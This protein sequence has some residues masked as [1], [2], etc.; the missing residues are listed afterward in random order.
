MRIVLWNT[1][2]GINQKSQI[3]YL[4][5]FKPD[6]AIL[7]ELKEKNIETLEAV[8]S[9]WVTNNH[10]NKVPKGLGVL[11][12][13]ENI[14][15]ELQEFDRDMEIYLPIIVSVDEFKFNLLAV[16]NF[17]SACKQG[18]FKDVKGEECLEY[19]A[20]RHYKDFFRDP[21]LIAGDWNLGP[22]FAQDAYERI[23]NML[24]ESKIQCLYKL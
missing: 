12:F 18:R 8:D 2:N 9:V 1:N 24:S 22:T 17:Y 21:C 20:L 5:S 15:L 6:L 4:K 16:W 10:K 3:D 11:S 19:S 13:R 14:K 7:P 23:I